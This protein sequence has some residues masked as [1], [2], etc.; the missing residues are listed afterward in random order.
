[1]IEAAGTPHLTFRQ[2]LAVQIVLAAI[3][4][5]TGKPG[6]PRE[7]RKPVLAGSSHLARRE[8]SPPAFVKLRADHIPAIANPDDLS[9]RAARPV[10]RFGSLFGEA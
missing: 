10:P 5:R 3:D 9:L 4:D 6:D 8:H 2:F 7:H 1:L